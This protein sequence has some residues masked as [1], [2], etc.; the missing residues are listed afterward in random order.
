MKEKI[1][2]NL[3]LWRNQIENAKAGKEVTCP[4]CTSRNAKVYLYADE[5]LVGYGIAKCND[6]GSEVRI[7]RM[8]FKETDKYIKV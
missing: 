2:E 7:C 6:C 3:L 5:N 4:K 1:V 8:L